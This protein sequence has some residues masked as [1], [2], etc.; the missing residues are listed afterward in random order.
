MC[1]YRKK[2]GIYNVFRKKREQSVDIREHT[3]DNKVV[4]KRKRQQKRGDTC[5]VRFR[6]TQTSKIRQRLYPR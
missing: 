2:R 3:C 4:P 1:L 5:E 6:I